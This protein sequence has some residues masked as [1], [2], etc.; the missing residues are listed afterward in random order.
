[1]C[2]QRSPG[3]GIGHALMAETL[4]RLRA[5]GFSE[6]ILWVLEDNPRTH[7]FYELAG[8]RADG[9]S[10]DEEWLDRTVRE[11]RYRIS[12]DPLG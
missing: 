11:I 1:M 8:W 10:K 3:R 2:S 4:S 5:D 9:A 12:F 7:R 6:A